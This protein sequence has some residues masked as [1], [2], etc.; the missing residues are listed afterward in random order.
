MAKTNQKKKKNVKIDAF[1]SHMTLRHGIEKVRKS[2]RGVTTPTNNFVRYP[3]NV[4]YSS[5]LCDSKIIKDI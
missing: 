4:K 2:N 5:D 1:Q 3:V